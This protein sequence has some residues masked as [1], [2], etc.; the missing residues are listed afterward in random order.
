MLC[1][2]LTLNSAPPSGPKGG[3]DTELSAVTKRKE[4]RRGD[5]GALGFCF[6]FLSFQSTVSSQK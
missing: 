5:T 1:P 6:S 3:S 2:G 4:E